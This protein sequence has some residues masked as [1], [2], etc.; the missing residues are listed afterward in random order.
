LHE[1]DIRLVWQKNK[2]EFSGCL[3]FVLFENMALAFSSLAT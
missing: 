1:Y 2:R 3:K